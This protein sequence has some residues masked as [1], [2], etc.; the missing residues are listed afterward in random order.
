MQ[1]S[2]DPNTAP[3]PALGDSTAGWGSLPNRPM[4]M[5][6]VPQMSMHQGGGGGGVGY[7]GGGR[8]G[9]GGR[10]G[11]GGGGGG[12]QPPERGFYQP[13]FV[14]DPWKELMEARERRL[15]QEFKV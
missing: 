1:T 15:Q 2:N 8:G 12:H 6:E 5:G 10:G 3:Y 13:S 9:R 7:R 4:K 11:G 14:E